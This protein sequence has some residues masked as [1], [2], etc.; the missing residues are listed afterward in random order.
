MLIL[1]QMESFVIC[2]Y[3]LDWHFRPYCP[4]HLDM[5][6]TC[7]TTW[8]MKFK[9]KSISTCIL[10]TLSMW[11]L[12]WGL[13]SY[14]MHNFGAGNTVGPGPPF[15]ACSIPRC[16]SWK[17]RHSPPE[18]SQTN[19]HP[20]ANPRAKCFSNPVVSQ[21][22]TL[23]DDTTAIIGTWWDFPQP[24]SVSD[25]PAANS[26]QI[27]PESVDIGFDRIPRSLPSSHNNGGEG[28][29]CEQA[30]ADG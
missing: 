5:P 15:K 20:V 2:L 16:P 23:H 19:L 6:N 7:Y 24:C 21:F 17:L 8:F 10:D 29:I 30:M 25:K 1:V 26:W 9:S 13:H 22:L 14:R 4:S 12:V 3:L 18:S 27:K 11:R 28:S